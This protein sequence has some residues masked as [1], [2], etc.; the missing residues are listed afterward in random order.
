MFAHPLLELFEYADEQKKKCVLSAYALNQMYTPRITTFAIRSTN[1]W[2]GKRPQSSMEISPLL[3]QTKGGEV[4]WKC[5]ERTCCSERGARR[6]QR[7]CAHP[8]K[9]F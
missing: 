4:R 9:S 5:P 1:I 6:E 2:L 8:K 3:S 7:V